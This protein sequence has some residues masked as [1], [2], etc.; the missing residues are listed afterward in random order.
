MN[1]PTGRIFLFP[2]ITQIAIFMPQGQRVTR[3]LTIT[4][5]PHTGFVKGFTVPIS[6]MEQKRLNNFPQ[7]MQGTAHFTQCRIKNRD[8]YWTPQAKATTFWPHFSDNCLLPPSPASHRGTW[9]APPAPCH[10][11]WVSHYNYSPPVVFHIHIIGDLWDPTQTHLPFEDVIHSRI[12]SR[13]GTNREPKKKTYNQS[14]L[15]PSFYS[16]QYFSIV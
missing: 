5:A 16:L 14:S 13:S 1:I 8:N 2:Y 11:I 6:Q 3:Q 12:F 9:R 15:Q 4:A 7:T 10:A